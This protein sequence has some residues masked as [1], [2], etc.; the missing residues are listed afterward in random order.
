MGVVEIRWG[1]LRTRRDDL[2]QEDKN[3]M[4][5]QRWIGDGIA[6]RGKCGGGDG[7]G[8]VD[9]HVFSFLLSWHGMVFGR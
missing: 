6:R 2:Y 8:S 3:G 5:L 4:G 1:R 7:G 9:T